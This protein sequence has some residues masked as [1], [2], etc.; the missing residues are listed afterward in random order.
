MQ[1]SAIYTRRIPQCVSFE[2]R[3]LIET[4]IIIII[5]MATATEMKVGASN[6]NPRIVHYDRRR[7]DTKYGVRLDESS[8]RYFLG[9]KA[10]R[11]TDNRIEIE[12]GEPI[13]LTAGLRELLF[14]KRPAEYT[15]EDAARYKTLLLTTD[16]HKR[17]YASDG[18]IAGDRSYKYRRVVSKLF[19]AIRAKFGGRDDAGD[20][21]KASAKRSET[22]GDERTARDS[23]CDSTTASRDSDDREPSDSIV[24]VGDV[25]DDDED[26]NILV[27]R[28]KILHEDKSVCE[29]KIQSIL[30]RLRCTR[31]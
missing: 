20:D 22:R 13:E 23:K 28:L 9:N 1:W 5:I 17:K 6:I 26:P 8:G 4:F 10:V 21:D 30:R 27:D 15:D 29:E 7:A 24:V 14:E 16:A 3:V 31:Q 11:L 2:D 12:G 18:W 25:D 19:P